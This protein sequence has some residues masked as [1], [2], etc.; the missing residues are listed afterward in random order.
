MRS[1]AQLK[2]SV[3]VW[4]KFHGRLEALQRD[5]VDGLFVVGRLEVVEIVA[6]LCKPS[7]SPRFQQR[8]VALLLEPAAQVIVGRAHLSTIIRFRTQTTTTVF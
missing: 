7:S 8:L 2:A 1:N 6:F 4:H 5:V 3:G